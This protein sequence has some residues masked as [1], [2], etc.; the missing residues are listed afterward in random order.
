[1]V[2]LSG[3]SLDVYEI[4]HGHT[5]LRA[6]MQAGL[7]APAHERVPGVVW[8]CGQGHVLGTYWHG[9]LENPQVLQALF[10]AQVPTLAHTFARLAQGVAQ[11]FAR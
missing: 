5:A 2:G 6:D 4:H 3:V 9:M 11:W 7:A 8:Q 1:M 10:G